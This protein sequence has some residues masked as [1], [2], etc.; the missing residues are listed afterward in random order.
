MKAD[1]CTNIKNFKYYILTALCTIHV[2]LCVTRDMVKVCNHTLTTIFQEPYLTHKQW[3][4]NNTHT[5]IIG[6]FYLFNYIVL[7]TV[8]SRGA[9]I[10]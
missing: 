9:Q 8:T 6:I 10:F 2:Q 5:K 4:L 7:N 3:F 1:N